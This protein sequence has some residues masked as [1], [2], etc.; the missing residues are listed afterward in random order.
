MTPILASPSVALRPPDHTQLPET[1][2]SIVED[3]AEL[4]Q[5]IL[6]TDSIAPV[7]RRLHPDGMYAIGGDSGIYWRWTDPPLRGCKAP[8]WFYV[9][10][11]APLLD[12]QVR[13]SY[14]MW[15]EIIAPL[16]LLEFVSGDGTEERD[17]TPERGKF[18]VYEQGVKAPYYG[19]YEIDPGRVEVHQLVGGRYHE[20][21]PNERGHYPIAPLGV[22]LGI[23]HGRY[24]N[25][26]LPWLRWF[27]ANGQLLPIGS[28]Q[29]EQERREKELALQRAGQDRQEKESAL[30]RA[31]QDRQD[32]ERAQRR[33]EELV[34]R[35]RA[36]GVDP[37]RP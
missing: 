28:E 35:L 30:Q 23:W 2:G 8:D 32:K 4:P 3:F 5:G 17:R 26:E 1:D 13:R 21:S 37:D 15:Q 24:Q 31:D 27:D 29:A 12:G 33:V 20:M 7:L 10:G 9:P 6:L 25:L 22:E 18:W 19:I 16:I 14:V 11:V 34:A 36:L